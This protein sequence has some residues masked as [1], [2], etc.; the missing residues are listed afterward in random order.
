MLSRSIKNLI[1]LTVARNCFAF[2]THDEPTPTKLGKV[3]DIV[4]E[5]T[6]IGLISMSK[7]SMELLR[8]FLPLSENPY[9]M[10]FRGWKFTPLR[11]DIA[12]AM[13]LLTGHTLDL[14][15]TILKV[16]TVGIVLSFCRITG[17]RECMN[18]LTDITITRRCFWTRYCT[19]NQI[20]D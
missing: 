10:R 11:T 4:Y 7:T 19:W 2:S 9:L 1:Q 3:K 16:L 20:Q 18:R 14:M 13:I 5:I 17:S 6:E 15:I 12:T 8:P